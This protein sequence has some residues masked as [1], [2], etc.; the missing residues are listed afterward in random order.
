MMVSM[1]SVWVFVC[2]CGCGCGWV[3]VCVCVWV[4]VCVC[5]GVGV[6]AGGW[7]GGWVW[8]R[9]HPCIQAEMYIVCLVIASGTQKPHLAFRCMCPLKRCHLAPVWS[10]AVLWC[11]EQQRYQS[12]SGY[13]SMWNPLYMAF[14]HVQ[15]LCCCSWGP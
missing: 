8:H 11:I 14:M 4:C 12:T 13:L 3:V 2:G 7:L 5:V 6:W 1:C 15:V 10:D 9:Q